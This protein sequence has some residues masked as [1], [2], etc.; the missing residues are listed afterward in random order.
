MA[1]GEEDVEEVVALVMRA[2]DNGVELLDL[3]ENNRVVGGEIA[4]ELAQDVD[5]LLSLSVGNEPS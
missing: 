4:S 2:F 1:A 5:R 3:G